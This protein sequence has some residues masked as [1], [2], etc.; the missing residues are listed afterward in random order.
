M[1]LPAALP[2]NN[3]PCMFAIN[4]YLQTFAVLRQAHENKVA[5]T[6]VINK[7]DKLCLELHLSPT[8]AYERIQKIIEQVNVTVSELYTADLM[9][10]DYK[11]ETVKARTAPRSSG[12]STAAPTKSHVRS[13]RNV[14]ATHTSFSW[15]SPRP[16]GAVPATHTQFSWRAR[17]IRGQRKRTEK[18]PAASATA[19][20]TQAK[21]SSAKG[22]GRERKKQPAV[23][24][25]NAGDQTLEFD[26]AD[27]VCRTIQ[28]L[29]LF[30]NEDRV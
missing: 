26:E 23:A 30:W 29:V 27:E 5:T 17:R 11:N 3:M 13:H 14:P 12:D 19:S 18:S 20:G 7:I 25:V 4:L 22:H 2:S 10:R 8:E 9:A 28:T 6:L 24:A 21:Q 1:V 16:D 15:L